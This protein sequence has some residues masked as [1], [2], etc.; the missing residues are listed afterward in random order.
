MF[1]SLPIN[2][3]YLLHQ[4]LSGLK[5]NDQ[6]TLFAIRERGEEL[7][8]D[9]SKKKQEEEPTSNFESLQDELR[10]AKAQIQHLDHLSRTLQH[11]LTSMSTTM[12]SNM[13]GHPAIVLHPT[14][15]LIRHPDHQQQQYHLSG[16]SN[17]IPYLLSQSNL[18]Y[19]NQNFQNSDVNQSAHNPI[20][21]QISN[22]SYP[23]V[24]PQSYSM[25]VE[26]N[27]EFPSLVADDN[28][29]VKTQQP[30]EDKPS[31]AMVARND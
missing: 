7:P 10:Q 30:D 21:N 11:Q 28:K 16:Y 5:S 4:G 3:K 1:N 14:T 13:P 31:Y 25:E 6:G 19:P 8:K 24:Q 20:P 12:P 17:P 18:S 22:Q 29:Q 23:V 15:P 27:T 26:K 2:L 9:L